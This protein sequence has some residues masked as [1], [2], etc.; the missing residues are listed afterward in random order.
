MVSLSTIVLTV[1]LLVAHTA[2]A[3]TC[4]PRIRKSWNAYTPV[5]RETYKKAVAKAMDGPLY[6]R[7]ISMHRDLVNNREAHGTC[8][9][10]FWHRQYLVGYENLLR[11]QGPEFA[12]VTLP[13]YDYVQDN[14][15]YAAGQCKS[16][17]GCSSILRDMG[18]STG[19]SVNANI[20]G[21]RVSG[22]CVASEPANHF[23]E[24]RNSSTNCLKC[25]PR[26][27]W[28]TATF[29]FD[30]G[31]SY[32]K[33]NVLSGKTISE[34]SGAIERSPHNSM[35]GTLSGAMNNV[36]V[37]PTEPVFYSHHATIDALH[38]IY[39]QCRVKGLN[40]TKAQRETNT[41]AFQGCTTGNNAQI[42]AKSAITMRAIVNGKSV[43]VHEEPSVKK[44]FEGLPKEYY[45]LT[46]ATQL[47]EHS[48]AYEFTG[49]LGD[50]YTNCDKSGMQ[51]PK[52]GRRLAAPTANSTNATNQVVPLTDKNVKANALLAWRFAVL[53]AGR[54][55][56]LDDHVIETEIVKIRAMYYE[57]CLEGVQ[58]FSDDFKA[59]FHVGENPAV[60]QIKKIESG[61]DPILISSWADL[62][63]EHFGCRGDAKKN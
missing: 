44:F 28:S 54:A 6:E 57:N 46:D 18:G 2:T 24:T 36:F 7:F 31:F 30:V 61:E 5:E 11:S 56:G 38:T 42:T 8:L 1:A 16:I 58:D 45:A 27:S 59:S 37:S 60:T 33:T 55:Q 62:N 52:T 40:L 14:L 32:I 23:C 43:P 9:F 4:G 10:L 39:H 15:A 51:P 21:N 13:Y 47:N 35:H 19:K 20:L 26:G 41:A 25:I 29:S 22:N 34:V 12:C 53:E 17:E 48:Y 3:A 63:Q 49:L 50:L